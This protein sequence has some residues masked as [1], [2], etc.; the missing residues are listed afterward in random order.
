VKDLS[1]SSLRWLAAHLRGNGPERESPVAHRLA[2]QL[3]YEA[4]ERDEIITAVTRA[5]DAGDE[6]PDDVRRV[7]D[8]LRD[9]RA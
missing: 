4:R 1:A 5:R 6:P 7:F 2:Q 8:R 3:E 9:E